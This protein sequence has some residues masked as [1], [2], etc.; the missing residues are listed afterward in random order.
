MKSKNSYVVVGK[1]LPTVGAVEKAS[2]EATFVDDICLPGMLYGVILGSSHAHARIL[3]ID[4]SRAE[5]LPGVKAVIT[6]KD[7]PDRKFNF[8][9]NLHDGLADQLPIEREKVRL[10]G[11]AVAA[12]AAVNLETAERALELIEVDYEVL[13]VLLDPEKAM[14]AGAPLIHESDPKKERNI[15]LEINYD[16]G[17]VDGGFKEA[18]Y[19]FEHKFKTSHQVPSCMET[20]GC[21]ARWDRDGRLT[22]WSS[23]HGVSTRQRDLAKL[24][25]VPYGNIRFI[26]HYVGGSFGGKIDMHSIEPIAA[27]LSKKAGQPVKMI[28]DRAEE[29]TITRTRHPDIIELKTGVKKDGTIVAREARFIQDNGAYNAIGP[30]VFHETGQLLSSYYRVKNARVHGYLV[31]TN[32]PYGSSF[33]GFGNPQAVFAIDSQMDIIAQKLGIDPVELRLKNATKPGDATACNWIVTSC[34]LSECITKVASAI[35]WKEKRSEKIKNRGVGLATCFHWGGGVRIGHVDFCNVIV[36]VSNGGQV[37]V[38]SGAV[39]VGSC[40]DGMMAQ[41][42]AEE[43]GVELKAVKIV[44]RDTDTCPP[45]PYVASP[46]TFVACGAAKASAADA[47]RQIL[48]AAAAIRNMNAN[49]MSIANGYIYDKWSGEKIMPVREATHYSYEVKGQPVIGNVRFNQGTTY[50]D[51]MTGLDQLSPT[52]TFG[53]HA[54]EVEVDPSTGEVKLLEVAAA[55]DVGQAISPMMCEGQIMGGLACGLGFALTEDLKFDSDGRLLNANYT[56]YKM[57]RALDMPQK[58]TALVVEIDDPRGPFGAKGVG[59]ACTVPV[60]AAIANAIDDAVGV[61]ITELPITPERLL[62]HLNKRESE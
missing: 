45:F 25:D 24:L 44:T 35:G 27:Y 32:K 4:T 48:E 5:Q 26:A 1:N 17:D 47:R 49:D 19:I 20:H 46:N 43:L 13:P 7:L 8:N 59:E 33:R 60:A 50:Y 18:D 16:F 6:G 34:G 15:S 51:M 2:G 53:A 41:V 54:V 36:E 38:Y 14:E 29:F 10:V 12:V 31:Y 58:L 55:Y 28:L 57:F 30:A 61:R 56:D 9:A 42:V 39:D 62:E 3:S 22:V 11:D 52:Y 37:Y 23:V 40:A 21:I